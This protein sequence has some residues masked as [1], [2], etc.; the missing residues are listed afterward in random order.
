VFSGAAWVMFA[1]PEESSKTEIINDINRDLV[2][3]YRVIRN[4]LEEFIRYFKYLLISRDEFQRFKNEESSTLTDI[5]R[6]VRFYYLIRTG[7]GSRIKNPAFSSAPSRPSNLNLLRIEEQLSAA[8]LRLSRVTIENLSFS[9]LIPKIDREDTFF[10]ID[11]PYYDY[12]NYYGDG[13]F[14][15]DDFIRL[16]ELYDNLNGKFLMSINDTPEIRDIY[17]GYHF[18]EVKTRYSIGKD[19]SKKKVGE[20]LIRN[21]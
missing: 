10:Y 19:G 18:T 13:I 5:Q 6:A 14:G 7:F 4:H 21:Y 9:K 8:H 17:Q 15:K 11:P 2:T 16:R 12:E 3:L 1:K 20:L